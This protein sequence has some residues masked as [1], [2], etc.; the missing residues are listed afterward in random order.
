MVKRTA[1]ESQ[2][3]EEEVSTANTVVNA[4]AFSE[5]ELRGIGTFEDAL[6]VYTEVT[7]DVIETAE[8][9]IGDGFVQVDEVFK[10]KL[11]GVPLF[12]MSWEFK[13]SEKVIKNGQ[14]SRYVQMRIVAQH[15]NGKVGKYLVS[16][17][18]TGI[19]AQLDAYTERTGRYQGLMCPNG[20]RVS[21]YKY[22]DPASGDVSDASTY[23][24][25]NAPALR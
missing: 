16:D 6:R 17:G 23:Y 2:T 3:V 22:T 13:V 21:D 9:A 12:V 8:G 19:L 5:S 7:G 4:R 24:I 18:S 15:A 20:L 10:R 1:V 11:I 14:P 25:D